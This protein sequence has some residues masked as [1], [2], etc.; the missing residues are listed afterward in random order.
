M[1]KGNDEYYVIIGDDEKLKKKVEELTRK[2]KISEFDKKIIYSDTVSPQ[3]IIQELQFL[4][5]FSEK[6]LVIVKNIE[7][8][9][10]SEWKIILD[11]LK[12][13]YPHVCLIL[14]GKSVEVPFSEDELFQEDL[15][16]Y[17]KEKTL[18]EEIFSSI[19]KD[20]S[21]KD[22]FNLLSEY[23]LKKERGFVFVIAAVEHLLRRKVIK[24]ERKDIVKKFMTLHQL[25]F[26]LKTGRISP[27]KGLEV[28][29][30][31][32]FS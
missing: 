29:L 19:Y 13:P 12:N 25:D 22:F 15:F 10:K 16:S 20:F 9:K 1:K 30:F 8:I 32:L 3:L 2:Y 21:S 23:L 11:Y 28:F 18:E 7:A 6:R 14:T 4:P 27:E 17:E 5:V 26:Y 24:G 31:Y